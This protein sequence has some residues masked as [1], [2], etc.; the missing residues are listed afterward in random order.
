VSRYFRLPLRIPFR[1]LSIALFLLSA[2]MLARPARA[3][4]DIV[5]F[6]S[7]I[8]V[9]QNETIHDAVCFF[10][11]VN[12]DGTVNGDIVVFFGNVRVKGHANHDV[13]NFFGEVTAADDTSIGHDLVNFFGGVRLGENVTVGEDAVVMFGSLNAA[14]TV[15]FGGSRVVQPGWIFWG[16]FVTLILGIYFIVHEVRASRRRRLLGY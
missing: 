12:V 14:P 15:N 2:A 13:V 3:A 6:G 5:E 11:S 8:D 10:C 9:R 7:N 16:P 4:Q 1:F